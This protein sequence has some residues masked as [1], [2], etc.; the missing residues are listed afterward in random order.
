MSPSNNVVIAELRD[1]L[2]RAAKAAST[3]SHPLRWVV[4]GHFADRVEQLAKDHKRLCKLL[5]QQQAVRD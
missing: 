1:E 4:F 3:Y 5:E 2:L